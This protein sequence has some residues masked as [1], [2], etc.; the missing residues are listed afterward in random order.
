MEKETKTIDRGNFEKLCADLRGI[1]QAARYEAARAVNEEVV[2]TYWQLG[3]RI[4]EEPQASARGATSSLLDRLAEDLGLSVTTLYDSLRFF[5]AYPG[6]LPRSDDIGRLSW[7]AHKLLLQVKDPKE[8]L[9]LLKE[10]AAKGLTRKATGRLIAD[11]R[12]AGEEERPQLQSPRREL[13]N[14]VGVVERVIDGDTIKVRIDLGFDVWRAERIR[15]RGIDTPELKSPE[16]RRARDF[17][18]EAVE[19]AP[20]VVLRTYK[21][22]RYARY[23]ADVFCIKEPEEKGLVFACGRFLNQELLDEGLARPMGF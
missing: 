15:L 21:T 4:A 19:E 9:H 3:E 18:E 1:L 20:Y 13:N 8:R 23:I 7:G 2:R 17:V 22:D 12:G 10:A 6:G 11:S 16:G 14:Y 5:R